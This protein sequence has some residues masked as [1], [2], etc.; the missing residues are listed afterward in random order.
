M[1]AKKTRERL[2]FGE[3]TLEM[4]WRNEA[5]YVVMTD[6]ILHLYPKDVVS[7]TYPTAEVT[8]ET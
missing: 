4:A 5:G 3:L 2:D 1:G 8:G 6:K 7:L